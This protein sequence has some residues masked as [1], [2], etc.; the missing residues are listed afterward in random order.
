MQSDMVM[1]KLKFRGFL[2]CFFQRL[3]QPLEVYVG[4]NVQV[5]N[6]RENSAFL[7][8][9]LIWTFVFHYIKIKVNHGAIVSMVSK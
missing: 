1:S 7:Y 4:V 3:Q 6:D 2:S 8:A 9:F 5:N